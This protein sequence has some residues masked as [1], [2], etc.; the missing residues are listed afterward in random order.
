MPKQ[1]KGAS[2]VTMWA[3]RSP[4]DCIYQVLYHLLKL[5][6]AT[7]MKAY[8]LHL[9]RGLVLIQGG[10]PRRVTTYTLARHPPACRRG[11]VRFDSRMGS[12]A[13]A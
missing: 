3:E 2:F 7:A 1:D 11:N 5:F 9:G 10:A 13:A 8:R 6:L 12:E 4:E